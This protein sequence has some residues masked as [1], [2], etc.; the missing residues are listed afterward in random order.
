MRQH[1]EQG[2]DQAVGAGSGSAGRPLGKAPQSLLDSADHHGLSLCW[3]IY[4][5]FSIS[6]GLAPLRS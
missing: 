3:K 2:L 1:S 6:L 5:K 4:E